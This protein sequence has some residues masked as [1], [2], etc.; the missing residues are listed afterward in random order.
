MASSTSGGDR[1]ESGARF[2]AGWAP[3]RHAGDRRRPRGPHWNGGSR[4]SIYTERC[5][6]S[7]SR[8][9]DQYI[10]ARRCLRV[11]QGFLSMRHRLHLFRGCAG[12]AA[13]VAACAG[14]RRRADRPR[15]RRRQGRS[16]PADQRRDRHRRESERVAEQLHGDDR[17][18]GT[19]LDHRPADRADGRSPRRRRA[20]AP[21]AGKLNV[22]TI[23]APNPPLTFTLKKGGDGG[24][25]SA[26]GSVGRERSA[27]RPGRRR[28]GL[29][30]AQKC[31]EAIAA[32][33]AIMAKAPALQ[34]HQPAD[35]RRLPQQEGLRQRDRRLQRAAE[36]RPEQ[37]QGDRRHRHDQPREGRSQGRRRRR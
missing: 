25:T 18:Q 12:R 24:P 35:R 36:G 10:L 8:T 34:R 11:V 15:R 14:E 27:G 5:Q 19:L 37:R 16:R 23:G 32:Y 21:E 31:D 2:D 6:T 4:D 28:C 17:R 1:R 26:L 9:N 7:S 13:V 22:Q 30:N 3:A 33:R 29:Y 20:S